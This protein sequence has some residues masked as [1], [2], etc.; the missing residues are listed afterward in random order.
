MTIIDA[1]WEMIVM[2]AVITG[3]IWIYRLIRNPNKD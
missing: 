1:I 2:A 3:G